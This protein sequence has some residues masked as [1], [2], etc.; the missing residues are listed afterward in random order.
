MHK[1]T[2]RG[3]IGG[4]AAVLA[5]GAWW[6]RGRKPPVGA[7]ITDNSLARA[8]ALLHSQ[9]IVD[10]HS[11]SGRSFLVGA[12]PNNLIVRLMR[13]GFERQ[14]AAD[15][16]AAQVNAGL[17]AIVA[18]IAVLGLT[19]N[20][21]QTVRP[22]EPGEAF[23][24]YQRQ[25]TRLLHVIDDGTFSLAL[26]VN[27][28]LTARSAASPAVV[29]S[30]EGGDFIETDVTRVEDAYNAGLRSITLLHYNENLL[31]DNQTGSRLHG[32]LT[33]LGHEVVAEMNRLGMVV[34]VAHA[35]FET[36]RDTISASKAPVMLSHS[37]LNTNSNSSP[38][39]LSRE[40]A[41]LVS[42]ADGIIGAWP[43]G[44]GSKTL[45]DFAAQ[46]IALANEVGAN[47]IAIGTDMD[48]NYKPVLTD[49]T[50]FVLLAALLL[51]QGMSESDI[52]KCLGGNFL[53]V[54]SDVEAV[55]AVAENSRS[56][57]RPGFP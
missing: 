9:T 43:A 37:N 3:V 18:D 50:D 20:G 48:G 2:R 57:T 54:F 42:D 40:H 14:R 1:W 35:S 6:L 5:T 25:L 10:V 30:C 47:H 12:S 13:D 8:E 52:G 49:Y 17:I 33:A 56:K 53:R 32:G 41:H 26:S 24:D 46:V 11:H 29:L 23:A 31:G 27:D 22:F 38:R 4:A 16:Q 51:Q 36:C 55:A 21:L 7:E 19:D 15:M 34:D 39:F 44:I 28:I 45:A